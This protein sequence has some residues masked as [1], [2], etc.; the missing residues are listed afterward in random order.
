MITFTSCSIE[1]VVEVYNP[2][3]RY[4]KPVVGSWLA[5]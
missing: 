5:M 4:R 1:R 3:S 2:G